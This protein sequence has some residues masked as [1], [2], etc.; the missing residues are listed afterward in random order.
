MSC[1][2]KQQGKGGAGGEVLIAFHDEGQG[3]P[4][5][6][7]SR[8]FKIFSRT[9][10]SSTDGERSTGLG[11]SIARNIVEGHGGRIWVES[12]F[13]KGSTFF[14]SLPISGKYPSPE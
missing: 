13:G 11:L 7:L 3:I 5:S 10:T 2:A 4:E 9:S 1:R 6:E 14:F 12:E 8:L